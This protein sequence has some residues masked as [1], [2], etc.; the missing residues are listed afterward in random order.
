MHLLK[1]PDSLAGSSVQGEG[2]V[3]EQVVSRAIRAIEIR[4][5]RAGSAKKQ[6]PFFVQSKTRPGIDAGSLFPGISLPCLVS[7]FSRTR[8]GVK[9]PDLFAGL[10]VEGANI[11]GRAGARFATEK[12]QDHPVFKNHRRRRAAIG[13]A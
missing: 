13:K 11:A 1:M 3:G 12:P 7:N 6:S 5:C 8:N 4:G 9:S 10:A 2:A